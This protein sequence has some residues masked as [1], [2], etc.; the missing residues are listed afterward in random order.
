MTGETRAD[1]AGLIEFRLLERTCR[2]DVLIHWDDGFLARSI[3]ESWM[4][5]ERVQG[6]T[7]E[8][9]RTFDPGRSFPWPSARRISDRPGTSER[10]STRSVAT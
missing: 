8:E 7:Q 4:Q 6:T 2:P 10:S 1:D 9:N 5:M 3:H